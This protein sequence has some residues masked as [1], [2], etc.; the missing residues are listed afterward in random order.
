MELPSRIKRRIIKDH[1]Q[2]DQQTIEELLLEL[3][4]Y[5]K[6]TGIDTERV[7][8]ATLLHADGK[9]DRLLNCIEEVRVDF[10]DILM[11]SGLEHADWP[12]RLDAEFGT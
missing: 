4:D 12:D 10:R 3:M 6:K 1:P 7:I 8:A 2:G 5:L 9:T 11:D